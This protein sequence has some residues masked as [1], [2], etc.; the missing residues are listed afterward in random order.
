MAHRDRTAGVVVLAI[1]TV[2]RGLLGLFGAGALLALGSAAGGSAGGLAAVVGLITGA[3]SFLL[4][5]V[6]AALW[7]GRWIGWVLGTVVFGLNT[8]LGVHQH[9]TASVGGLETVVL[10]IDAVSL[11]YLL[12]IRNRFGSGGDDGRSVPEAPHHR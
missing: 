6:A 2:A 4:L 3:L 7:V 11:L 9:L 8:L 5:F 1:V 12:A 10:A